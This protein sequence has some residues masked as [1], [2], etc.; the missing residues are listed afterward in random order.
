MSLSTNQMKALLL[1][2][3]MLTA[4]NVSAQN[5]LLRGSVVD[6]NGQPIVGA[7]ILLKG[8]QLGTTSN[9][10]GG[11]FSIRL[12]EPNGI[13]D[14][15][16]PGYIARQVSV[17]A[18]QPVT[19]VLSSDTIG[20][21]E[22]VDIVI[23]GFGTQK[24]ESVVGAISTVK[25]RL[26]QAPVR[27]LS[28]TLAGN[29][30]GI[31]S[32]Q[33][34]GEPGKDDAQFWIRG[35]ST[36]TGSQN[37]LI[38]VDGIERPLNDV[39]PLEIES[40]SVLKDASATAV[41]GV[42]GANGVIIV[43][44]RRGFEGPARI[45]ARYE[46]GFSFASKRL[47]FVDAATRSTLF[48]EAVDAVGGSA[49][50]KYTDIEIAAMRNQTDPEL[51]PDVDWQKLLMKTASM[52]EKVSANISGGGRFARYFTALSFY[53][54]EGQYK[55]DPGKYYWVNDGIGRFGKNI[56]YKRYN[57]RTNVDMN[58]TST[59]VASI[60]IQG[61]VT[62]NTE[63]ADG[64]A[65]IYR[66]I[67]NAAP[68]A[69]PIIYKDG[70]LAGRDG[71]NNP[72]NMLTQ[73][74]W[75]KTTGNTLRANLRID[76]NLKFITPGLRA[77]VTYAY[78]AENYDVATR[79]RGINYFE[80]VGRDADGELILTEWLASAAQDY[81]NYSS[82]ASGAR[83]QYAEAAINYDR[84]FGKEHKH[85]VTGLMLG[86]ARGYRSQT[87]SSYINSLPNRSLG[88]AG[89]VTYGYDGR[90]LFEANIGF[91]GSEN[92]PKGNRMGI[93]PAVAAGWVM[94]EENFMKNNNVLTWAKIR[95]S[96]GQVGN[97][98][99]GGQRFMYLTTINENAGGYNNFGE[100]YD[101]Y[102]NGI[103]EG[104]MA[105]DRSQWEVST[106]YNLGIELGFWK[107]LTLNADLFFERR[108]K[109]FI[110]PQSSEITGLP[111]GNDYKMYANLGKM[112]NRG[113]EVTGEYTK[114]FSGNLSLVL[115]GNFT[116]ARNSIVTDGQYYAYDWQNVNGTRYGERKGY[117]A[118]HLF[119]QE[120]LDAMP[121]YYTQF[122]MNKTQ[123]RAGDIRYEDLNDDG[124]IDEIDMTWMGNPVT[125]EIVYGFGAELKYRSFDFSFLF[126]GAGN[127]S[128]YLSAAW[129]FYPFQADRG[130]KH[131]GNVM[132]AFLDRWTEENPDPHAFSPRLSYGADANNYKT[133]TWWLRES[134]YL[135][136]KT[137]EIG[138]TLPGNVAKKL[139]MNSLRVYVMGVNPFTVGKFINQF[140]D[141]ET[142]AD[143]YPIQRQIFGGINLTF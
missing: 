65:A 29:L 113:F 108:D 2:F 96:F 60:G 128:S 138:Y 87:A 136:L 137:I 73:M 44:T 38:L 72:Y 120:E 45:D 115:R 109:I 55:V 74:G 4:I 23:V 48:N 107:A 28:Q 99:I 19:V 85:E 135:R 27:S 10:P 88:L 132:S 41:Y 117:R 118:M 36:F 102:G 56:N 15:S 63:P 126:Q 39:D 123:L 16:F 37:P 46:H 71:L 18:G 98:Q 83:T 124:K 59:T 119:S 47:S 67:I 103:G 100:K 130:P 21:E 140:W 79:S 121:D 90:Y 134:D 131:M 95:A 139:G 84:K 91:N 86:F 82:G 53:N 51:Y 1:G 68:N 105:S 5:N 70:K 61:N 20:S 32:L 81:L 75:K 142:G 110:N 116:F 122:G 66:D 11:E 6:E 143:A 58:I 111:S 33:S 69:F 49:A 3:A 50:V 94:S 77:S 64:S 93:F 129:Y 125:P 14:V 24:K 22:T 89:R 31:I 17:I 76:Q 127:R 26:L 106:K 12:P 40:F 114:S 13:L 141:P 52:S 101:K 62:E 92:F 43:T 80:A 57:F 42:R 8:T 112:D 104:R 7:T 25:P 9:N 97:D 133:S 30:A 78:D 34:S 54:Q 35:I